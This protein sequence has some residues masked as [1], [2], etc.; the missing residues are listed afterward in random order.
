MTGNRVALDLAKDGKDLP[1]S[2]RLLGGEPESQTGEGKL[3][4][5][6]PPSST[7]GEGGIVESELGDNQTGSQKLETNIEQTSYLSAAKEQQS[8]KSH[9][10]LTGEFKSSGAAAAEDNNNNN[11]NDADD[12]EDDADVE[13]D[14]IDNDI[15]TAVDAITAMKSLSPEAHTGV[16]YEDI[17]ADST[18]VVA[19]TCD[20]IAANSFK[21]KTGLQLLGEEGHC[22]ATAKGMRLVGPV[23]QTKSYSVADA[24][25]KS[26]SEDEQLQK[27]HD[28]TDKI[29][30]SFP[31]RQ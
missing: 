31:F 24:R 29:P 27:T 3:D 21:E 16:D 15:A 20:S 6:E 25:S 12:N 17:G 28:L 1:M 14:A 11:N 10:K 9:L 19:P 18:A 2:L 30:H 7:I 23:V 8:G 4:T 5:S 26:T 22:E 13:Q